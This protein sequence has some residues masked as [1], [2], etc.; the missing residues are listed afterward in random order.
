MVYAGF[1]RRAVAFFFDFLIMLIPLVLINA[2]LPYV[3]SFLL[4]LFYKPIFEASPMKSTPGK[5]MMGLTVLSETGDRITLKQ[6]YIRYFC[7]IISGFI[8]CVGYLM[9]LFTAKRQTLHDMVAEVVVVKQNPPDLNYFQ[10]WLSE[11]KVL[12]NRLTGDSQPISNAASSATLNQGTASE[13]SKAIEDLHK[14][15]QSGALSQA[16]YESK[17]AELLKKI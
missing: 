2:L 12:F 11:L 1:W 16:E 3:G 13:V 9:N 4:A 17:K 5:A 6:A 10:V 8:M 14:L 7:S 15:Y